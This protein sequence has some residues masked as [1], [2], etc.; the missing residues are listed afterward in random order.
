MGDEKELSRLRVDAR[1][2][3]MREDVEG[4]WKRL[5]MERDEARAEVERLRGQP[6]SKQEEYTQEDVNHTTTK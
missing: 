4:R 1:T 3:H 6:S 5:I 2:G